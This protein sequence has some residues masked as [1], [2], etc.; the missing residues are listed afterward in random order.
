MLIC[1][2]DPT[3]GKTKQQRVVFA[4]LLC[5][6]L[7]KSQLIMRL[8][9]LDVYTFMMC[10]H[11]ARS[12]TQVTDPGPRRKSHIQVRKRRSQTL[13][14][15]AGHRPMSETQV[16]DP[17]PRRRLQTQGRDAGHISRSETQVTDPCPRRRLQ[18]QGRDA[19]H[20]SRSETQATDPGPRRRSQTQVRDAGYRPRAETQVTA[21]VVI[22]EHIKM[23]QY[24]HRSASATCVCD[25]RQVHRAIGRTSLMHVWGTL[26]TIQQ[27][28]SQCVPYMC[29]RPASIALSL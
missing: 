15:D 1:D 24:S 16:T 6:N 22:V 10:D 23:S 11:R 19:S 14:R 3:F 7:Y 28:A 26:T 12:E 20:I 21:L 25:L 9:V 8:S 5:L 4:G 29:Q 17:C 13:V 2:V 18:T 27:P